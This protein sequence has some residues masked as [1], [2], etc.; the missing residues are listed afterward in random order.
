MPCLGTV[1]DFVLRLSTVSDFRRARVSAHARR[2]S[3]TA[4]RLRDCPPPEG[5]RRGRSPVPCRRRDSPPPEERRCGSSPGTLLYHRRDSPPPEE[6]R[7]GRMS[8]PPGVHASP[9]GRHARAPPPGRRRSFTR[10]RRT[11]R[12]T[13]PPP[14][15]RR[16]RSARPTRKDD[17]GRAAL[18]AFA[19]A[20]PKSGAGKRKLPSKE[21]EKED[22]SAAVLVERV[23]IDMVTLHL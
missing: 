11:R 7:R 4:L 1:S 21:S 8:P 2:C 19:V 12:S 9:P 6:R 22:A 23:D 13:H 14:E 17:S 3:S 20:T 18:R 16:G 10:S 15:G 5:R